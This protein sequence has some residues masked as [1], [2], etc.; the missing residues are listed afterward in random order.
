MIRLK[1]TAL[2]KPMLIGLFLILYTPLFAQECETKLFNVTMHQSLKISEVIHN[3]AQSCGLSVVV[4][5]AMAQKRLEQTLY[6]VQLQ[7]ATLTTLLNT[8]LKE[9]NLH[10]TLEGNRLR[11]AYLLT[12]TFKVDYVAGS[13]TGKSNANIQIAN[14]NSAGA[15]STTMQGTTTT[16]L[17]NNGK[18]GISIESHEKFSFWEKIEK[19]V[20]RILMGV[21]E[22]SLLYTKTKNGWVDTEGKVWS[23]NPLSPIVNPEAGVITVTGTHRQLERVKTYMHTVT[24]QMQQ[25]VLIDVRILTVTFSQGTTLGI[26]WSQLYQ[27]QN[28]AIET[29]AIRQ[30]NLNGLQYN[31][32]EGFAGVNGEGTLP[33][34]GSAFLL[35]GKAN[36]SEIVHFLNR[37]GKV[38]SISSPRVMTL[39]N[40]PALISV[41]KELF[42]KTTTATTSN[43]AGSSVAIQ[44]EQ[45]NSVFAGVLLDITPQ[46]SSHGVITLKVNPSISETVDAYSG[47][48]GRVRVMPPDLIRRQIASVIKMRHGQRAILGGLISSKR[49]SKSHRLP[50]LGDLPLVGTLFEREESIE[51]VEELVL[52]ITPH[53]IE[54]N[55]SMSLKKLGY[56]ELTID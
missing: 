51:V 15:H 41:G 4:K 50:L 7:N 27:L 54:K 20:E 37:Q 56:R 25:Q 33:N 46:I 5:D 42:Y 40:Q 8:V 6:Y 1:V 53:I 16:T 11:I 52:I 12:Q 32:A 31:S 19:E 18:T 21:T 39:N 23:Y 28:V 55:Q 22:T 9:H 10:Y 29:L 34:S 47:T 13:R 38:N 2:H 17:H 35:N 36:I 3:I 14:A 48:E 49:G 24:N 30:K 44:G 26:D 43:S 45:V